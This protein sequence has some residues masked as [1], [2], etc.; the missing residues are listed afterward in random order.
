[1]ERIH[2]RI[3]AMTLQDL[4]HVLELEA[5]SFTTPWDRDLYLQELST[6]RRSHY[7]VVVP[8]PH[9]PPVV[10][11]ILAQGG[12]MLLGEEVHIMTLA[13]QPRWRRQGLGRWLLLSMLDEARIHAK[14]ALILATL[15]VRPSNKAALALYTGL[16]FEQVGYRKRYYPDQEDA[17]ILMLP[18]LHKEEVWKPLA[19]Q[20][21]LLNERM[22]RGIE[23]APASG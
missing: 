21:V 6:N 22:A 17:L 15:E 1:M 12:Y 5:R 4:D 13:V 3:R 20:L 10:P 8:G 16:G 14:P 18:G 23:I 9:D 7:R 19:Y 2:P 11:P